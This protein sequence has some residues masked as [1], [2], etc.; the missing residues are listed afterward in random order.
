[1]EFRDFLERGFVKRATHGPA[2]GAITPQVALAQVFDPD[3]ALRRIVKI[4]L[5]RADLMPGEKMRDVHV[6]L[7]LGLLAGVFHEHDAL[8][9]G[10]LDAVKLPVRTRLSRSA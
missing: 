9:A 10:Q 5:R 7:V 1:M 6:T 8:L 4:D 3:Q 2:L